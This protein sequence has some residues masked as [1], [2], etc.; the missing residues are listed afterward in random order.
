MAITH[1]AYVHATTRVGM[2]DTPEKDIR[3][4][5]ETL[6]TSQCAVKFGLTSTPKM[7]RAVENAHTYMY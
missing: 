3:I 1:A 6:S 2:P 5:V 7:Q 4:D